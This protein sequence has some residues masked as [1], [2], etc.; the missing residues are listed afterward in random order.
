MSYSIT[1]FAYLILSFAIGS[2]VYRV[3]QY[4]KKEK[5]IVSKLLFYIFSIFW[6][7]VLIKAIGGL[8]F[9]KNLFF[10]RFT[11]NFGGFLQ[12]LAFS[13]MAYFSVYVKFSPKVS[14]WLG[15]IPVFLLGMISTYLTIFIP[16]N[17]F[18]E[19]SGAI[20]WGAPIVSSFAINLRASLFLIAFIPAIFIFFEQFQKA[21]DVY[22]K[23]KTLGFIILSLIV[24]IG[25]LFDFVFL[26]IGSIWRDI[27][28]IFGGI[29][30]FI[31]FA[32]SQKERSI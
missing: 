22:T 12:A 17:P 20:N 11:V 31:I 18:L 30:I 8:F 14:P 21:Q 5:D 9:V 32:P 13:I 4:W 1:G 2:L 16:F 15:F 24:I 25:A 28:F 19:P 3:F 23:R 10:L 27:L 6:L 29:I 7:F 26:N